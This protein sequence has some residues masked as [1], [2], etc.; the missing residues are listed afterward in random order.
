[1]NGNIE[2]T[3]TPHGNIDNAMTFAVTH[4]RLEFFWRAST[5]LLVRPTLYAN[6]EELFK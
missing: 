2:H 5:Q 6:T 3:K 1:M 4:S